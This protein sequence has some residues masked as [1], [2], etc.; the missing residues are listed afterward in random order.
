MS[1]ITVITTIIIKS[2]ERKSK[3][4]DESFSLTCNLRS[5]LRM[6][7]VKQLTHKTSKTEELSGISFEEFKIYIEFLMT[8]EMSWTNIEL[9]HVRP[10]SSFNLTDPDQ[11]KEAAHFSNIQLLL[12][13]D[14]RKKGANYHE[15][16]LMVQNENLYK[17][18]YFRYYK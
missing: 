11:L 14:N 4:E 1:N 3:T 17:N 13:H 15:H 10:L 2:I 12:K 5:R 16:D 9:D 8:T 7:L 18:E 6:A